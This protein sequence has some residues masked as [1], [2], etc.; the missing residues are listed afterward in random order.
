MDR[1]GNIEETSQDTDEHNATPL[2]PND[3]D[4]TV[5]P[6][7]DD[8]MLLEPLQPPMK[9]PRLTDEEN[10]PRLSPPTARVEEA[11]PRR[12][13]LSKPHGA[14]AGQEM[15]S[16]TMTS[17]DRNRPFFV[18]PSTQSGGKSDSLH[19]LPEAFSPHRRGQ[20]FVPGG[21]ADTVRGWIV[22]ITSSM[23]LNNARGSTTATQ[24][25][26]YKTRILVSSA[27]SAALG[28]DIGLEDDERAAAVARRS[29]L[30]I[31][32]TYFGSQRDSEPAAAILGAPSS[33][34]KQVD[35]KPGVVV[36]ISAPCWHIHLEGKQ[37]LV[38][39]DWTVT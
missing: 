18:L 11:T 35:V 1:T 37:W 22:D 24:Q 3:G 27:K 17:P 21:M 29:W 33:R 12:F 23:A 36:G 5:P 16:N 20:K 32:G 6:P 25:P 4:V 30:L 2:A 38:G 39:V 26:S 13:L 31:E 15:S 9:R 34:K 7:N 14:S 10:F 28:G 8:E 19:P